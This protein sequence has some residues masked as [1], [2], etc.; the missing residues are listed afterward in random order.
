[1]HKAGPYNQ[2]SGPAWL[3]QHCWRPVPYGRCDGEVCSLPH[4][5]AQAMSLLI[6][7]LNKAE[8]SIFSVNVFAFSSKQW[9]LGQALIRR[10]VSA[11]RRS[12]C[13]C[14]GA[15]RPVLYRLYDRSF[16]I[17]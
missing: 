15:C 3:K 13:F 5:P 8:Q 12:V 1:M 9:L 4:L 2:L 14:L 10:L 16:G 7:P 17:R 11:T 6:E